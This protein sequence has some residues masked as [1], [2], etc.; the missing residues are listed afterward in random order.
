MCTVMDGNCGTWL[1]ICQVA[2][3]NDCFEYTISSNKCIVESDIPTSSQVQFKP[4]ILFEIL[5]GN[6]FNSNTMFFP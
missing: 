4:A 1:Y 6:L 2:C 3:D 5:S